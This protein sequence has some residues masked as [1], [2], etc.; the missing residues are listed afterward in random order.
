M[1]LHLDGPY[2][3]G[4]QDWRNYEVAVLIGGGIGVTPYASILKDLIHATHDN[5]HTQIACKK[6]TTI[7]CD[8]KA[9]EL[10]KVFSFGQ[11]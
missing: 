3:A 4:N 9:L 11:E 10:L 8:Y 1:Q 5:Q 2:G 6:V 7:S